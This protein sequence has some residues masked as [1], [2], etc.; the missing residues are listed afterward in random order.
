MLRLQLFEIQKL[1]KNKIPN[2]SSFVTTNILNTKSS[3]VENKNPDSSKYITTRESNKLTA[4]NFAARLKQA[5]L[6]KKTDF[7]NKLTNLNRQIASNKT[8]YLEV[9][10]KLHSLITT[11]YNFL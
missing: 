6:M 7:D 10:K 1:V 8:K 2:T 5:D 11:N 3:E 9:Q 4:E